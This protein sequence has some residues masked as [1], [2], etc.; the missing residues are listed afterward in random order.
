MGWRETVVCLD[1]G[2]WA[3]HALILTD[4]SGAAVTHNGAVIPRFTQDVA[5]AIVADMA[6]DVDATERL[7]WRGSDVVAAPPEGPE[8]VYP[9][10]T[11]GMYGIGAR[12]WVWVLWDES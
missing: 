9:P 12:A 3:Y 10:D 11:D 8:T 2:E 5:R 1:G 6:S 7:S 4:R